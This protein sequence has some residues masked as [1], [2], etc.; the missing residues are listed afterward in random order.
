M[1][2]AQP[3]HPDDT[4]TTMTTMT[5]CFD[6]TFEDVPIVAWHR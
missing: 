3:R 4:M 1:E 5:S 2:D 6:G